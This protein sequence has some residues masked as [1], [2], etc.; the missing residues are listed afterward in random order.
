MI[1]EVLP[2]RVI[3]GRVVL[4]MIADEGASFRTRP[5]DTLDVTFEGIPGDRHAGYQ[6]TADARVP[7]YKRGTPMANER[8]VSIVSVEDL[9]AIAG[10][11]ALPRV[12]PEWL[13]ANIVCEGLPALSFLPRGTRLHF[14]SGAALVVS[15][16][17]A[18]CR[19]PGRNIAAA[20]PDDGRALDLLFPKVAKRLRGLT[21]RVERVGAIRAGDAI[22]A[23]LPEQWIYPA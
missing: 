6:K 9:S 22:D 3:H 15:D 7:W 19:G 16:Q 17:N 1:P 8:H 5:T 10:A 12:R 2:A 23:R 4:A 20:Y 18:P 21:L 13:G 11:M 14:P